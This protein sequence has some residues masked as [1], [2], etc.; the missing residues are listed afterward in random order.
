MHGERNSR[1][2]F[3]GRGRRLIPTSSL[4]PPRPCSATP[5]TQTQIPSIVG[6]YRLPKVLRSEIQSKGSPNS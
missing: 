3:V 4:T 5:P 6:Q 2:M 1:G